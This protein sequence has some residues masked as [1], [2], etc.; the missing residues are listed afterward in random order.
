MRG[1][2]EFR[3]DETT[4][5]RCTLVPSVA[6]RVRFSRDRRALT[7][8]AVI[9]PT[10][11]SVH[12]RRSSAQVPQPLL[13]RRQPLRLLRDQRVAQVGVAA[14]SK[15]TA[16]DWRSA[17]AGDCPCEPQAEAVGIAFGSAG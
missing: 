16:N 4:R 14:G 8:S 13:F 10:F 17:S 12:E 5:A 6:A 11:G 9:A 3:F 15:A 7:E 1:F 2:I